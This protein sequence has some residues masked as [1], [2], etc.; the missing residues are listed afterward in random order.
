MKIK[1][2]VIKI[3]AV[4]VFMG[5]LKYQQKGENTD[6]EDNHELTGSMN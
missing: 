3:F 6:N 5:I 2:F 4:V 1:L